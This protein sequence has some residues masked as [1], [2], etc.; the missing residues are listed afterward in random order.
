MDVLVVNTV[1]AE[2]LGAAPVA[3]LAGAT[4]AAHDLRALAPTVVVTVGAAG[5]V[6]ATGGETMAIPAHPVRQVETLGAG[7]VFVGALGTRLAA[8]E[9]LAEAL[10]YANAA[11]ALHVATPDAARDA[12]GPADV[13]RLLAGD[14]RSAAGA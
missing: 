5:L 12:L 4:V 8:G 1:E 7:D 6:A 11:A 13:E 14:G 3:D 2:M 9:P 10:R